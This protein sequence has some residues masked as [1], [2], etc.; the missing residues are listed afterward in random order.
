MCII[1]HTSV[2][3]RCEDTECLINGYEARVQALQNQFDFAAAGLK[4]WADRFARIETELQKFA[5]AGDLH[6][7]TDVL[8][9]FLADE[10]D[11]AFTEE[12]AIELTIRITANVRVSQAYNLQTNDF[13]FEHGSIVSN[14]DDVEL[15]S[16]QDP[17]ISDLDING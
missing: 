5:D 9:Q 16:I 1:N 12:H 4:S 3:A 11:L 6:L 8:H 10:F 15:L 2:I 14:T 13:Y 7:D 17:H